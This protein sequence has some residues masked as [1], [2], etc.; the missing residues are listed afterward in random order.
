MVRLHDKMSTQN[1]LL[2]YIPVRNT[3]NLKILKYHSQ[4]Y[5]NSRTHTKREIFKY[6]FKKIFTRSKCKILQNSDERN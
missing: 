6:K 3:W 5:K 4:F 2:P 1:Q